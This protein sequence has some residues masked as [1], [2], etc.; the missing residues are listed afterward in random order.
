MSAADT[1]YI[2]ENINPEETEDLLTVSV[3]QNSR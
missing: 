3:I 1:H 2:T